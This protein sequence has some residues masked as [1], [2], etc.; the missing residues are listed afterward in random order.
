MTDVEVPESGEELPKKLKD[1]YSN[2][3]YERRVVVFCD[4]LGWRNHIIEAGTDN[5][6]IGALRRVILQLSRTISLRTR[7]DIKVSTLSDNIAVTQ[8]VGELTPMLVQQMA[9]FQLASAMRGFFLRG[10]ITVGDV[11]HDNETVFGSGL[12]R[13]YELE[14]TVANSARIVLD[15]N[16]LGELGD[17]G[18]LAVKEDGIVFLDP[19]RM[20][21]IEFL[22]HGE[23]ENSREVLRAAGLPAGPMRYQLEGPRVLRLVLEILKAQIRR[24]IADK[25]YNKIE[26]LFDRIAVQLGVPRARSY[27][28]IKPDVVE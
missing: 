22:N 10:G 12:N 26:W 24:P 1:Y 23:I 5:E 27:P 4:I 11:N 3:S 21:Y 20:E 15:K 18:D 25:E 28:R 16:V 19:F 8:P 6:K 17:I 14:S 13:A 7:L 9:N 2:P